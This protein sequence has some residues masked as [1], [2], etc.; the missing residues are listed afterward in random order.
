MGSCQTIWQPFRLDLRKN[1]RAWPLDSRRSRRHRCYP[2][3]GPLTPPTNRSRR[4]RNCST[5]SPTGL[6]P[7]QVLDKLVADDKRQ[8][9]EQH[10]AIKDAV[11][12]QRDDRRRDAAEAKQRAKITKDKPPGMSLNAYV[13][14]STYCPVC[15]RDFGVNLIPRHGPEPH[16]CKGSGRFGVSLYSVHLAGRREAKR[17]K[18]RGRN[19][20]SVRTVPG[21]LSGLG[22]RR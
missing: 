2:A 9:A 13:G 3:T 6:V 17:P 11:A 5:S 8:N 18:S 4:H 15:G 20:N 12:Q 21:G 22:R 16:G 10:R 14:Q 7:R 19:S 1:L